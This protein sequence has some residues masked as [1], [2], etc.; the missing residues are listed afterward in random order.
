MEVEQVEVLQSPTQDAEWKKEVSP[1][2]A[3][4]ADNEWLKRATMPV[5]DKLEKKRKQHGSKEEEKE[6]KARKALILKSMDVTISII[7]GSTLNFSDLSVRVSCQ[8]VTSIER[9][10]FQSITIIVAS[11]PFSI[12]S[13]LTIQRGQLSQK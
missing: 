12:L 8:R 6:K 13:M 9:P 11:L 5:Q 3:R 2:D 10:S 7:T 4:L 1:T